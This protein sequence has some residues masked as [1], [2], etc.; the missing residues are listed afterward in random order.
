MMKGKLLF[1]AFVLLIVLFSCKKDDYN[2]YDRPEWLT[3]KV[4]TQIKSEENLSTFAKCLELTGYD[5]VID[6][7]G[8]YT[9]FAP[10]NDAFLIFFQNNPE[11]KKAEDIPLEKLLAIVKYHI[12][13]NPW[14]RDQL[15]S[16]D[17]NGW[18][19]PEDEF[20]NKPRGFKRETLLLGKDVKYGVEISSND[21]EK[22]IIIDTTLTNW[23]RKVITDSRKFAPIFFAEYFGIY[24]L[25]LS[26]YNFY[27]NRQFDSSS[28]MFFVNAKLIGDEIFA[29]NGF[30]HTVD[31]VVEPLKNANEI[32]RSSTDQNDY[33]KFLDLVNKF[34]ALTWNE[35][36]TK[37]QPGADQ[38]LVVD[39][40]FDLTYPELTF[41]ITSEKTKAPAGGAGLPSDVTIRF[42]HGLLAPTN[43]A[44]DEFINNYIVGPNQWGSLAN[45]PIKI[46]K[47]IANSYFSINPFY[48]TDLQKGFSNGELDIIRLDNSSIVQK[49]FG[50]NCT[51]LGL[52]RAIV[53]RAFKS[54]T[55][56]VYRQT[57]Y[58]FLMNAIE[59]S[60]MLSALKREGNQYALF[61]VPD[62]TLKEDSS[63]YYLPKYS[64]NS[65]DRFMAYQRYD[66]GNKTFALSAN[67]LRLL[68][69]NQVTVETPKGIARKE[70][71]KTLA[72]NHIVWD[73]E[74]GIVTGTSPSTDGYASGDRVD[75]YPNK[76][77]TD[78]DNGDTY[79][80][81]TFFSFSVS[82]LYSMISTDF[83]EFHELLIKSGLALVKQYK[84]SFISEN[85]LY[86]VFVP[87]KEALDA[88]NAWDLEGEELVNFLKLH[89]V[90]GE[91]IFTDGKLASGYYETACSIPATSSQPAH[92]LK[93]YIEP[94]IDK[95]VVAAKDGGDFVS[96]DESDKTNKI[97][98]RDLNQSGVVT[99]F[100]NSISTA[101]IHSTDK[102]LLLNQL[103]AK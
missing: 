87:T 26:D 100:K 19:D 4:Y 42:H 67:D 25:Q 12:V 102:A 92:N 89:F 22:L 37:D 96:I 40:L 43:A 31:R 54:V 39:S 45:V 69:L 99:N 47:I 18:I 32:L 56:P 73:N 23:N 94:G 77:S 8:S 17:V 103:D 15:R 95:V 34:P 84:Y 86:T 6:I 9:V 81:R 35:D 101:V 51:F 41:N 46:Q 55:G 60:G 20:N 63:L 11:Y 58:S 10:T 13:Q 7:S 14:S 27:F 38:G 30:I 70:F 74:K 76:I 61:V 50:S 72:G 52:N 2:K 24:N 82:T 65:V 3:G 36:K 97:A 29:E 44:F 1:S 85:Q 57:G 53:P 62:A 88:A 5:K 49:E 68:L 71:L 78:T 80:A 66:Q 79:S 83:K 48:E 64:K 98:A 91:L 75:I 90:T 21:D 33:S 28:D 16:L 59:Y 93:I